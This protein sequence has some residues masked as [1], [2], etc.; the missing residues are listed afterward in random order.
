MASTRRIY[1]HVDAISDWASAAT[2]RLLWDRIHALES[3]ITPA[4]P[5]AAPAT[6]LATTSI[7][8]GG[9]GGGGGAAEVIYATTDITEADF[10]NNIGITNIIKR[11]PDTPGPGKTIVP[12]EMYLQYIVS[13]AYSS[14]GAINL[15]HGNGVTVGDN[16]LQANLSAGFN[17]VTTRRFL[18]TFSLSI[19]GDIP[20]TDN[21][22]IELVW[23]T[24]PT[25]AATGVAAGRVSYTYMLVD[26]YP[27][28]DAP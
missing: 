24:A 27:G 25:G 17:T 9:T 28:V 3:Q 26:S 4:A 16:L 23:A 7:T 2:I 18:R 19:L 12:I 20:N 15:R 11:F 1:P 21:M 14:A 10:E 6:V 8:L 13:V 22:G 5:A